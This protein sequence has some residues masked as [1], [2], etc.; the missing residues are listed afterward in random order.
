MIVAGSAVFKP[1]ADP[2]AVI[3]LLRN[4]VRRLGNGLT[5]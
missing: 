2:A 5:D 1:S 4:S 3:A